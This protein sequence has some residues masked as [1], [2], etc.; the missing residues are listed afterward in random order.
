M[1]SA[2]RRS[3]RAPSQA[4]EQISE[5]SQIRR[6]AEDVEA[7]S[8]EEAPRRTKVKKEKKSTRQRPETIEEDQNAGPAEQD[9][10][11][12]HFDKNKYLNQPLNEK[13]GVRINGFAEDW[14]LSRKGFRL[15]AVE[16]AK[17]MAGN[18]A[19][20]TQGK[21]DTKVCMFTFI[22]INLTVG[23]FRVWMT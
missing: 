18:M 19:E 16:M 2:A 7:D 20:Y 4:S 17:A 3:R 9:A 11:E 10:P 22:T 6:I 15:D 23:W 12:E 14:E 5:G 8:E 1:S 21:E 13:E